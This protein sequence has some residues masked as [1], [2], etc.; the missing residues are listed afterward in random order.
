MDGT[1]VPC[2]GLSAHYCLNGHG[3]DREHAIVR[4]LIAIL[5]VAGVFPPVG[6]RRGTEQAVGQ[7]NHSL[8]APSVLCEQTPCWYGGIKL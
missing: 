8:C 2:D 4:E 3:G 7:R 5:V 1:G 6:M